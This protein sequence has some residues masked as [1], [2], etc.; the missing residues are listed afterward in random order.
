[1][2]RQV[3]PATDQAE[4][5]K[6]KQDR[7]HNDGQKEQFHRIERDRDGERQQETRL[8]QRVGAATRLRAARQPF[9]R[10]EVGQRATG[11]RR[12]QRKAGIYRHE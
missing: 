11:D 3:A 12:Y 5:Q 10:D 2:C 8:C 9:V 1:M 6:Q 4:C 7:G